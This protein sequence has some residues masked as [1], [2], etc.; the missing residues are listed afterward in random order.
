M[1][2]VIRTKSLDAAMALFYEARLNDSPHSDIWACHQ[3]WPQIRAQLQYNLMGGTYLGFVIYD[4][5]VA[6]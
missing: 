2:Q 5:I 1:S 3:S 4:R 6:Q